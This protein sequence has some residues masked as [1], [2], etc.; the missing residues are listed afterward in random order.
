MPQMRRM[1]IT[2]VTGLLGSS[3]CVFATSEY[4][5]FGV[6]RHTSLI[7]PKCTL[8]HL[9]LESREE[10]VRLLDETRPDVIVHCAAIT[11][12]DR[13]EANPEAAWKLHVGA[14]RTLAEWAEMH[15]SSIVH[16][17]TDSVFDGRTGNYSELDSPAPLNE[18]A[19]T[20][21][22][23]EEAV[24]L[25][26]PSALIV[27]T[28]FYG[29]GGKGNS[30][31][32]WI[33]STLESRQ[34]LR[35][36]ED[37]VF[38]PLPVGLLTETILELLA[39]GAVGTFHVGAR[40]ACSKYEF[41]RQCADMFGFDTA[42]VSPISMDEFLFKA[43]RPKDTSLD[44]GK[45]SGFLDRKMPTVQEG[46]IEFKKQLENEYRTL[47]GKKAHVLVEAPVTQ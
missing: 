8:V 15:K 22:A 2:G 14:S 1:L 33:L 39:G 17:S 46:L 24:R 30:Y 6:A 43:R 7:S 47:P 16:V 31:A 13:C 27:R 37:V 29:V 19:R 36:F 40:N 44:V 34:Q 42:K 10:T 20:K 38:N 26:N 9:D 5:V 41:A 12:V 18:Y 35:G 4:D 23:G 3:I 28:N 21:L 45:V 32:E 25:A 11:D